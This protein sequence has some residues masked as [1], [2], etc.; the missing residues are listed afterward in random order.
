MK[1]CLSSWRWTV[2]QKED[3]IFM[4]NLFNELPDISNLELTKIIEF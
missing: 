4:K 3:F 2:D 1:K